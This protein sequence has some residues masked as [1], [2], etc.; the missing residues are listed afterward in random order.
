MRRRSQALGHNPWISLNPEPHLF[1][2][3]L[4]LDSPLEPQSPNPTPPH[5]LH[6]LQATSRPGTRASTTSWRWPRPTSRASSTR[7]LRAPSRAASTPTAAGGGLA[8]GSCLVAHSFDRGRAWVSDLRF[9]SIPR[10]PSRAPAPFP[11]PMVDRAAPLICPRLLRRPRR[12]APSR[13]CRT[14]LPSAASR[15][16]ACSGERGQGGGVRRSG[17]VGEEFRGPGA[18]GLKKR[19]F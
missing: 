11:P 14:C 16:T 15:P 8:R 4:G 5:P 6:N 2:T 18:R 10:T 13:R 3:T 9:S 12:A 17:F 7:P 19:V 1:H